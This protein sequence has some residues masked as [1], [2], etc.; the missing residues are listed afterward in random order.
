MR[1]FASDASTGRLATLDLPKTTPWSFT[2]TPDG[3]AG[4]PTK[5][6][7]EAGDTEV[8][9]AWEYPSHSGKP[10]DSDDWPPGPRRDWLGFP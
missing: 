6:D 3:N 2:Y 1:C 5:V 8:R 4:P 7:C 9:I 10:D